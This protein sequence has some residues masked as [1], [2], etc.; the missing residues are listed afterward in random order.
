MIPIMD[1]GK[2]KKR[3]II[4]A[5]LVWFSTHSILQLSLLILPIALATLVSQIAYIILGYIMYGKKVFFIE[6][7]S[8]Q[9]A[10]KFLLMAIFLWILNWNGTNI[11]SLM[12]MN[13]NLSAFIMVPILAS[14]SYFAQKYIVYK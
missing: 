4:I 12:G 13:K 11:I 7:F 1:I 6:K 14:I 3:F 2:E 5:F 9:S 10:T 8:K